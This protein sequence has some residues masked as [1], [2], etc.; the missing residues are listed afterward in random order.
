MV[1]KLTPTSFIIFGM[2]GDLSTRKIL[3]AI[4]HLVE[5]NKLNQFS[6]LGLAKSQRTPKQLINEAKKHLVYHNKNKIKSKKIWNKIE[7][8]LIYHSIDFKH[9]SS[10]NQISQ[11]LNSLE[12]K[13]K[14]NDHRI[15]YLATLP[16]HFKSISKFLAKYQL[17]AKNS[18]VMYE[19]P[20][21]SSLITAK[22]TNNCIQ[23]IFNEKQI[24]RV[25]H[26]L[27]KELVATISMLRFTNRLL[28]PLWCS[29][30][31]ES[32][33]IVM[34]EKIEVGKRARYYDDYGQVKDV[35]QN[36]LLQLLSLIAMEQ[37]KRLEA[38]YI[39]DAKVAVLNKTKFTSIKRAQYVGYKKTKGVKRNSQTETYAKITA[40]VNTPRWKGVPF[41]I[42]TGKALSK[43][44][45]YIDIKFKRVACLL[46]QCPRETN[47]LLIQIHPHPKV[48]LLVNSKIPGPKVQVKPVKLTFSEE[49]EFGPNTPKAYENLLQQAIENDHTS[50]LRS[51]GVEASWKI[52]EDGLKK[53][54]G[55]LYSYKKASI[56]PNFK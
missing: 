12:K 45:T 11:I 13:N 43:K 41:N 35:V 28:E 18:K 51:D 29:E 14:T 30:H 53:C 32:V 16:E 46:N 52:I 23:S 42:I 26:Y 8:S 37:P 1:T 44:E 40:K 5:K 3:P 50:F 54:K 48:Q 49:L 25:D 39:R 7:K 6:I 24:F 9:E 36:H 10:F 15:F 27:A 21:A 2:G 20:F 34:R 17:T 4:Y 31:I 47:Q 56:E 22:Q 19:K 33:D 38:K 55:K